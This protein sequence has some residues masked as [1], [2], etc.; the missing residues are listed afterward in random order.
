MITEIAVCCAHTGGGT[1]EPSQTVI[2]WVEGGVNEG[3]L[4]NG[5]GKAGS[6]MRTSAAPVSYGVSKY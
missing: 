1:L 3:D 2:L 5:H 4:V 6:E